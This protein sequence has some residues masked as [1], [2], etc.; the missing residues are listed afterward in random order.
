MALLAFVSSE[1]EIED[2]MKLMKSAKN[3][4]ATAVTHR[5]GEKEGRTHVKMAKGDI[6]DADNKTKKGGGCNI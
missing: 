1:E 3:N 6:R 2:R 4:G 5:E